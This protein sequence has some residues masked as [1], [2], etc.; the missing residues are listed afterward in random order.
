MKYILLIIV[1][2]VFWFAWT[3][4]LLKNDHDYQKMDYIINKY[5]DRMSENNQARNDAVLQAFNSKWEAES[6]LQDLEQYRKKYWIFA[7]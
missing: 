7:P 1:G 3:L 6:C 5:D 4:V 2:F